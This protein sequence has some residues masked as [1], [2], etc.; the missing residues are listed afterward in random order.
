MKLLRTFVMNAGRQTRTEHVT[1]QP[2]QMQL[3][4]AFTAYLRHPYYP[5]IPNQLIDRVFIQLAL[6]RLQV[7]LALQQT[8]VVFTLFR[9]SFTDRRRE[10]V[11]TCGFVILL[12]RLAARV[13]CAGRCLDRFSRT[14]LVSVK[15]VPLSC[16]A[17]SGRTALSLTRLYKLRQQ[18]QGAKDETPRWIKRRGVS[19]SSSCH[20]AVEL[21]NFAQ[22]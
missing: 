16:T 15:L 18:R 7:A 4:T 10:T 5:R 17:V 6:R 20:S 14:T 12:F 9:R 19:S 21:E 3:Q 1:L 22:P 11:I 2:A 8:P 13:V